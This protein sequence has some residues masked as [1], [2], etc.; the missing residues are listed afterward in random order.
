MRSYDSSPLMV[1]GRAWCRGVQRRRGPV[2]AASPVQGV[3]V[4]GVGVGE[5]V[6]VLLGGGD[7]GVAHAVH[8]GF[9]V[10]AS[11][12]EPGGVGVAEVADGAS[13]STP[14]ALMAGSQTRVRKV[15]REIGVPSRVA[16]SRSSGPR[17][18]AVIAS[19]SWSTRS[20]GRPMVRASLSFG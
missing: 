3:E 7:L 6:E 8:D 20:A 5:G 18:R 10:A 1:R 4:L 13:K 19:A 15:F 11:C 14:E 17:C 9:E 2:L 16:N 12:E